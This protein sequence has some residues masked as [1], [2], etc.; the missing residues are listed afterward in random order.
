VAETK[1]PA[2]QP[3]HSDEDDDDADND[4]LPVDVTLDETRRILS[5]YVALWN[6]GNG[7]ALT[8]PGGKNRP[9]AQP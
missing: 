4:A 6:N 7:V 3:G 9:E 8:K 1:K 5:D 2:K